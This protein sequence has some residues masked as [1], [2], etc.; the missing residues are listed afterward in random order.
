MVTI[1]YAYYAN[2]LSSLDW[3]LSLIR[4]VGFI[5]IL[6]LKTTSKRKEE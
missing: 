4:G 6:L 2:A 1:F 5:G 3:L